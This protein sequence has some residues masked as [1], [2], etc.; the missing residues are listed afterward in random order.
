MLIWQITF[1]IIYFSFILLWSLFSAP[2][3][4][5]EQKDGWFN[6][7]KKSISN[8]SLYLIQFET[9]LSTQKFM[10]FTSKM[11]IFIG[12]TSRRKYSTTRRHLFSTLA[13]TTTSTSSSSSSNLH[14][15]YSFKP[16]QSLHPNPN[17]KPPNQSKKKTKP[18]YRPPSSLDRT[19]TKPLRSDL[20][21]DFRFSYTESSPAVRPIG[22]REPKYSPFGPGR[23]DREWTGVCAPAVNPKVQ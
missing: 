4:Q 9:N 10:F 15:K 22:L 18:P 6:D 2:R 1:N 3:N 7:Y 13:A 8:L 16:P 12:R 21:F 14:Q 17:P 5:T 20:P 19:G 23:L 11:F